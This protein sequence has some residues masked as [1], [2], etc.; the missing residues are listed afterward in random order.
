MSAAVDKR[1]APAALP[2]LSRIRNWDTSRLEQ[3]SKD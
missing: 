3:A 1:V 2:S